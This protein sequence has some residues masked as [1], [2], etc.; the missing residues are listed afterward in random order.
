M[1]AYL[2]RILGKSF[3]VTITVET[4]P[5]QVG[6][7]SHAIKVTVDGPRVPRNKYGELGVHV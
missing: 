3:N 5:P 4:N 1:C 7:Y 6:T 2:L